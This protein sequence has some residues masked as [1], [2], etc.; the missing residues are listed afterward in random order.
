MRE[1][2]TER[3]LDSC[4]RTPALGRGTDIVKVETKNGPHTGH[5]QDKER[6]GVTGGD[7]S[8]LTS[9]TEDSGKVDIKRHS[10]HCGSGHTLGSTNCRLS[11]VSLNVPYR[12][13]SCN[14]RDRLSV[15]SGRCSRPVSRLLKHG[16]RGG[17]H[18][19]TDVSCP[20]EGFVVC[21][22]HRPLTAGVSIANVI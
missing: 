13:L 15:S 22:Y 4:E 3:P 8:L 9:S 18:R 10:V 2:R 20:L 11:Q 17:K 7:I 19:F 6:P 21:F 1:L 16:P 12:D 14:L 5:L